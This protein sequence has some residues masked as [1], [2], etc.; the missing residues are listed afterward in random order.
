MHFFKNKSKT[1]KTSKSH[2]LVEE[3]ELLKRSKTYTDM[4]SLFN[5]CEEDSSD[6]DHC[7]ELA[8]A[9]QVKLRTDGRSSWKKYCAGTRILSEEEY[10]TCAKDLPP[11]NYYYNKKRG[12]VIPD[13]SLC[14]EECVHQ[15]FWNLDPKITF[16][17]HEWCCRKT[18]SANPTQLSKLFYSK[19]VDTYYLTRDQNGKPSGVVATRESK[20]AP[21]WSLFLIVGLFVPSFNKD[22]VLHME[23]AAT[24]AST[25]DLI[26][27]N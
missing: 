3:Q 14:Y 17:G 12:K 19:N 10:Y 23:P 2:V 1:K 15:V 22:F 7:D 9:S 18:R 5:T 21:F 13:R 6:E 16:N 11:V 27:Q 26:I 4:D 24:P 8:V 20:S 25:D